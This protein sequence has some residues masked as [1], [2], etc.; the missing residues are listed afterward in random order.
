[1]WILEKRMKISAE[2]VCLEEKE[3][4]MFLIILGPHVFAKKHMS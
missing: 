1:M 2:K 4:H 3:Y